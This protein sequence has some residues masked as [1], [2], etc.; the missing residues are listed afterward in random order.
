MSNLVIVAASDFEISCGVGKYS[1]TSFRQFS[2]L[3]VI[4]MLF[5]GLGLEKFDSESLMLTLG[6]SRPEVQPCTP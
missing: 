1:S 4:E 3:R 2:G 5:L 6:S